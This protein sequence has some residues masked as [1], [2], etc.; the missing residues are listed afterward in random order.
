MPS[1]KNIWI[2]IP[3]ILL[4]FEPTISVT[5]GKQTQEVRGAHDQ[6]HSR[7]TNTETLH[8]ESI[9]TAGHPGNQEHGCSHIC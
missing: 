9:S 7:Q 2:T 1:V 3:T 4:C 5:E 6:V 8:V